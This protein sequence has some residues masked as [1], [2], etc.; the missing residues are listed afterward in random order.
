L[1]FGLIGAGRH[2]ERYL[3]HL[4]A[5]DVEGAMIAAF[6]RRDAAKAAEQAKTFGARFEPSIEA[7]IEAPDVDAL[8]VAI[9]AGDHE[10]VACAI[11]RAKKPL[12]LEKPIAPTVAIGRRIHE[13]FREAGR[14]ERP[15]SSPFRP[16]AV[17]GAH[18]AGAPL[19]IAQTLR[20]DPLVVAL[21]ERA[22]SFG[23]LRSFTFEQRLE[24]RGLA[25]E[26]EPSISGGGVLLQTAIHTADALRF[27]TGA[28]LTVL[29]AEKASVHYQHNEDLAALT[30]QTHQGALGTLAVSKIGHARTLRFA[31]YFDDGT[32][33]ADL[34]GRTLSQIHGRD[35]TD[36]IHPEQPT[37]IAATRA[38][39]EYLQGKRENPVPAEDAIASLAI[40]E[41]AMSQAG[42]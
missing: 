15:G 8:I 42:K 2:G 39:V 9:P 20:F 41:A 6:W 32:L 5:G 29:T 14:D 27:I 22:L 17:R 21:K 12:L 31:L 40:I 23:T 24:P 30:L 4:H 25:W 35:R 1:R 37:V 13:A 33:E 11:A 28:N 36:T 7:L 18:K 16:A 38:F 19:M 34:V 3:R 10:R 26:D